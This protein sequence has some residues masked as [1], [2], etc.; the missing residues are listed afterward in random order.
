[1]KDSAIVPGPALLMIISHAVI[2]SGMLSTKPLMVICSYHYVHLPSMHL[3]RFAFICAPPSK[4]N[5]SLAS[6]TATQHDA[7]MLHALQSTNQTCIANA[8][9]TW[10]QSVDSCKATLCRLPA[11]QLDTVW[12]PGV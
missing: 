8:T 9:Q 4:S 12:L 7:A 6:T 3:K 1:M 10:C 2:H 11:C 5:S